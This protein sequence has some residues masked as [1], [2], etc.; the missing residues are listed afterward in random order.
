MIRNATLIRGVHIGQLRFAI[1]S[2]RDAVGLSR[3]WT[4][5]QPEA[6]RILSSQ[7]LNQA[8]GLRQALNAARSLLM[9]SAWPFTYSDQQSTKIHK[10]DITE[11]RSALR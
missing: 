9:L 6:G 7:L 11:L 5:Y 1:D 8:S 10:E 4:S 2:V 3:V